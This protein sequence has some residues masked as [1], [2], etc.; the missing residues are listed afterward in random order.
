MSAWRECA[1]E[2]A[3]LKRQ[4]LER[5]IDCLKDPVERRNLQHTFSKLFMFL[6]D[7]LAHLVRA[8]EK[9]TKP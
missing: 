1:T 6:E 5:E 7:D 3:R 8:Y 9:A 2:G 4:Q